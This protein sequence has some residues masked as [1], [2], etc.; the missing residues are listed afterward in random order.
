M[1]LYGSCCKLL[2]CEGL[3][4]NVSKG[5]VV[6]VRENKRTF[7]RALQT[8]KYQYYFKAIIK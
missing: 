6:V 7:S 1:F 2:H 5:S 3:S 8:Y 4:L